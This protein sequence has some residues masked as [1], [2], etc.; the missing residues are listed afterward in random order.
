ML[1]AAMSIASVL[2]TLRREYAPAL[3]DDVAALTAAIE[4]RDFPN[5]RR[6][7]HRVGGTAGSYGFETASTSARA[8]QNAIDTNQHDKIA[9]ALEA[10]TLAASI[11]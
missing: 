2:E 11:A 8:I 5:A 1:R 10:L 9:S 4:A 3:R 7:A 6:I